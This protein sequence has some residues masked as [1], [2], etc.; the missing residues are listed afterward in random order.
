MIEVGTRV[1]KTVYWII[2]LRIGRRKNLGGKD[3]KG[4]H[5]SS[6]LEKDG[7]ER[8]NKTDAELRKH[9]EQKGLETP[10]VYAVNDVH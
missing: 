7:I 4:R 6:S 5:L 3:T 1:V 2:V 8:K 10:V 9:R